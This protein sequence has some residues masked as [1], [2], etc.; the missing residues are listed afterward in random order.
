MKKSII[1][2]LYVEVMVVVVK[3]IWNAQI[4]RVGKMQSFVP[5]RCMV[6]GGTHRNHWSL[7]G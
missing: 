7:K 4:H 6:N 3:I 2:M 1:V 5:L